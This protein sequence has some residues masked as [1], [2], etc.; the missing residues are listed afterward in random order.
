METTRQQKVARLLQKEIAE[1]FQ[2]ETHLIPDH[3]LITVT[4]VNVTKDLSIARVFLSIFT[5]KDKQI[6]MQLVE[7]KNKEIRYKL[8]QRVKHQLRIVPEL[9][10]FLDDTLDYLE[11][12][13]NLLKK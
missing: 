9:T 10:F 11:N 2:T 3:S 4:R 1:I 7:D 12:I 13:E 5:P 6:S 8:G